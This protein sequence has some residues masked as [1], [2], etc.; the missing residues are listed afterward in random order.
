MI[1]LTLINQNRLN[2]SERFCAVFVQFFEKQD[3]EENREEEKI[4]QNSPKTKK[5]PV[6]F[7][8]TDPFLSL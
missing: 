6:V 7:P 5:G 3:E 8:S 1:G 2:L 4:G